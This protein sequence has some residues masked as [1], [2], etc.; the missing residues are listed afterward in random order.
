MNP[1][2]FLRAVCN[3]AF[4]PLMAVGQLHRV[5]LPFSNVVATGT[6]I[7]NV[8]PGRTVEQ[9]TLE[10]GG[11]ALTKAMLTGVR[12]KANGK[13]VVDAS[14]PQLDAIAKYRGHAANAAFL[15]IFF[16]DLLGRNPIDQQSGAFDTSNNVQNVTVEVDIAGATTPTLKMLLTESAA[17]KSS[18]SQA[19]L[20]GLVAKT[21]RY[22]YSVAAGGQISIPLPFGPT[23][24]AI[25]KRVHVSHTNLTAFTVK[26]DGVIVFEGT[27]AEIQYEQ[28]KRAPARVP[29]SGFLTAD[30]V[31]DCEIAKALDTRDAR[32]LE[33][34]PTFSGADSGFLIVEYLDALGNL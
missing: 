25:I 26:Q 17:Q 34:F 30:F 29:Q 11:G 18:Q 4:A 16:S 5:G 1:I 6:A 2:S 31:L 12:V 8:T 24:G 3:F 7:A 19:P 14:G 22:P 23:S 33:W 27:V 9:M 13:P 21:L 28:T 20:S 32:S 15:D 10:L